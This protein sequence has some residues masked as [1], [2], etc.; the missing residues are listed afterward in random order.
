[1]II[2][3]YVNMIVTSENIWDSRKKVYKN[4]A[5]GTFSKHP[6][7]STSHLTHVDFSENVL[8]SCKMI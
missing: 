5:G 2:S 7:K 8:S 4:I 3:N 1:M 6:L